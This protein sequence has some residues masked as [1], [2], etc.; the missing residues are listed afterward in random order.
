[1]IVVHQISRNASMI[2]R[3]VL[4]IIPKDEMIINATLTRAVVMLMFHAIQVPAMVDHQLVLNHLQRNVLMIINVTITN[5]ILI[6]VVA[7]LRFHAIRAQVMVQQALGILQLLISHL[8]YQ[9][10]KFGLESSPITQLDGVVELTIIVLIASAQM[11]EN[12]SFLQQDFSK[13]Q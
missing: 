1:M 6:K 2:I 7:M 11:I 8:V 9:R 12:P 13:A 4:M 10:M 3:S 5:A